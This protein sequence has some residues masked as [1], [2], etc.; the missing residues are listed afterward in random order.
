[1]LHRVSLGAA[2][3]AALLL[4]FGCDAGPEPSLDDGAS[5]EDDGVDDDAGEPATFLELGQIGEDR[6]FAPYPA[7]RTLEIHRGLQGGYHVFV[8]G[9]LLGEPLDDECLVTLRMVYADDG[10]EITTIQHLRAPELTDAE[11]NPTLPEMIVFLPDPEAVDGV[12]VRVEATLALDDLP[13]GGDQVQLHLVL[14]E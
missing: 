2:A 14:A 8:D 1:M 6:E 7:G 9:R 3:L 10:T 4:G 12:D 11:G 5:M 13:L